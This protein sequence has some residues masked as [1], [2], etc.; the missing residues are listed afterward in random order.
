MHQIVERDCNIILAVCVCREQ[1]NCLIQN[2]YCKH[3]ILYVSV[4]FLM[5]RRTQGVNFKSFI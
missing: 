4:L 2:R 3:P 5:I 1:V